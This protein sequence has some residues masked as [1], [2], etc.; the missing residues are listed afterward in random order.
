VER[1]SV[2]IRDVAREAGVSVA[3]VSRYL[4]NSGYIGKASEEKIKKVM[5]LLDYKPNE[6]ARGLA[7]KKTNS[8]ALIIPDIKNPFFPELVVA[9]ED[10]AKSKGYSLILVN[11]EH[12]ELQNNTFWRTFQ[13]RY[14]DG[15]IIASFQFS[16]KMRD[17][18]KGLNIP[19][20][21]I[22][23]A[24]DGDS[25]NSIEV[26]NYM[27]AKLATEHLIE[28]GCKKIAHVSGL[29]ISKP[30]I[31]RMNGFVDT[32]RAHSPDKEILTYE[33]DFSLES[34]MKV[35]KQI[36][37]EHEDVD[38]IFLGNDLMALGSLKQLQLLKKKV[39]EEIAII[40]F[41]GI[42]LTQMVEPEISTIQ[43]PIYEIGVKATTNLI[44][45]I[46]NKS[47]ELMKMVLDVQLVK[48]G[49]TVGFRGNRE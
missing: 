38:G 11:A 4:N 36:L 40:G 20:V 8:I 46:E 29:P 12:E 45:L 1:K 30:V 47:T 33:G 23:R 3:T 24:A 26:D 48:R 21:K 9:I 19:F 7:K 42:Q 5:E 39:P 44:D 25:Y 37:E 32:I 43:Q 10:V 16:D 41:D 27:G 13:N 2:T 28:I 17:E 49:S 18:L 15:F 6:I 14:V 35:T 34:G 22:D 31:E